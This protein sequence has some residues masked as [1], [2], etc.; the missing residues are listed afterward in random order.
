MKIVD[1]PR[2]VPFTLIKLSC[3]HNSPKERWSHKSH[4]IDVEVTIINI[5]MAFL[6]RLSM[7]WD[8]DIG[9]KT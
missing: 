7:C 1:W 5:N 9:V 3:V 6:K 8:N 2:D 4:G